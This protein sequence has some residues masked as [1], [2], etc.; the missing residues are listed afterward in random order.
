[1]C[2]E[3]PPRHTWTVEDIKQLFPAPAKVDHIEDG[4]FSDE[5]SAC[6][7]AWVWV[8]D[9]TKI[10]TRGILTV[11]EPAFQSSP[12]FHRHFLDGH[13]GRQVTASSDPINMLAYP[14]LIHLDRVYDYTV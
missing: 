3:G 7:C 13:P 8:Q 6:C 14:V 1:M 9:A 10:A 2:L 12:E 11:E 5:E 4:V